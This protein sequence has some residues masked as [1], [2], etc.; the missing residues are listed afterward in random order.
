MPAASPTDHVDEVA[1]ALQG[2]CKSLAEVL[3][4]HGLGHLEDDRAFLEGLD[5]EVFCCDECSW[6]CELSEMSERHEG[7]CTDCQPDED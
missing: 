2:T 4:E 7:V 5:N 1:H 3:E 6:W